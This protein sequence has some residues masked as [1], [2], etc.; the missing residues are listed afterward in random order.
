MKDHYK[1]RMGGRLNPVEW[2][3]AWNQIHYFPILIQLEDIHVS[4]YLHKYS[5][6]E[7]IKFMCRKANTSDAYEYIIKAVGGINKTV[8]DNGI[9]VTC[10]RWT[11]INR[12]FL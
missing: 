9:V 12:R 2:M 8:T 4:K 5:K 1:I 10:I 11:S 7:I 3:V 6:F